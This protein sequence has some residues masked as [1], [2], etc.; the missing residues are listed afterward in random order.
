MHRRH[1]QTDRRPADGTSEQGRVRV[2]T[3]A[4]AHASG[5]QA[6]TVR[7]LTHVPP[8]NRQR[9]GLRRTDLGYNTTHAEAIVEQWGVPG[10]GNVG[11]HRGCVHASLMARH[12]CMK[13]TTRRGSEAAKTA[14]CR[15]STPH[16]DPAAGGGG[17]WLTAAA[18]P[19][20]GKFDTSA[21]LPH[22]SEAIHDDRGGTHGNQ[23]GRPCMAGPR[24]CCRPSAAADARERR[25]VGG[26]RCWWEVRRRSWR[27][28]GAGAEGPSVSWSM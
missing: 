12:V 28:G 19:R 7:N 13:Q 1:G 4:R 8:S 11:R 10:T 23:G 26:G 15:R 14:A 5:T 18:R 2:H 20:R 6:G 27:R 17:A 22:G 9:P 16:G 3:A 24:Q 25:G 21:M